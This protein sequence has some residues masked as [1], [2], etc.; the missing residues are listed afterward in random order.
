MTTTTGRRTAAADPHVPIEVPVHRPGGALGEANP[1]RRLA[2]DVRGLT[3]RY[4]RRTV[5][6]GL[7]I[8]V[9]EGVV[10]GFVGPNGAGKTT[11]L[12]M[13]L[14]LVRP[15]SGRGTVL[16]RPL[17]TPAAYLPRVGAL[18]ESPALYP[19]LSGARNL[20]AL[21]VLGGQDPARVNG[22]LDEVGLT[23]RG[24]DRVRSYSL[25]MKQ[26]LAIGATL[27]ADPDLLILDEPTNGLD[28]TGI[29]QMRELIRTLAEAPSGAPAASGG[30]RRTRTVLISS[31]LLAEVEQ[32]C[33]W[34]IVVEGGRLAYQGPTESLMATRA[35]DVVLRPEHDEDVAL[36]ADLL[37]GL[38]VPAVRRVHDVVAS[39]SMAPDSREHARLLAGINRA[40]ADRGITLIEI[41]P[42]RP[43]L[44]DRYQS[45]VAQS[46]ADAAVLPPTPVT[47]DPEISR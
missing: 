19:A 15:S 39:L 31:H 32:I 36:V 4:G 3:K 33:D 10:A 25:G 5:V 11:T 16:G 8:A 12:R 34:L 26:R 13:L 28:P 1:D 14:G 42:R 27:L 23:G 30:P 7:D 38:S 41:S 45:L 24:G 17:H 47:T 37:A 43:S 6:S 20:T 46:R 44:E 18:I 29:R 22:I 35:H 40:A 9:P 21:A 2:I